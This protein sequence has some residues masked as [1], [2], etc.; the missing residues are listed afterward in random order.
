MRALC[1]FFL[2][3]FL[4]SAHPLS[5][6]QTTGSLHGVEISSRLHKGWGKFFAY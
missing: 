1:A 4:I 5:A 3:A 2:I 6:Q